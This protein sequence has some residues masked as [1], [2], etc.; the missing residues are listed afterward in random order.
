MTDRYFEDVEREIDGVGGVLDGE[1]FRNHERVTEKPNPAGH[2][3][4][5]ECTCGACNGPARVTITWP[6]IIV[7]SVPGA[8]PTNPENGQP[9]VYHAG[10]LYPSVFCPY[11]SQRLVIKITPDRCNRFLRAGESMGVI[12]PHAVEAKRQETMRVLASRRR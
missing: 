7:A 11:C 3:Y 9:W 4:D 6:E 10:V 12:N 2:G 8:L 1:A 5:F